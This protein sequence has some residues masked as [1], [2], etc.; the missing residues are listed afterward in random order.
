MNYALSP[1]MDERVRSRLI[2]L[3]FRQALK[4]LVVKKSFDYSILF[5]IALNCITLAMERP[6]IPPISFVRLSPV[7]RDETILENER[8]FSRNDRFSRFRTMSSL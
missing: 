6:S 3:R 1:R 5:F 8:L 7:L 2:Y 4:R